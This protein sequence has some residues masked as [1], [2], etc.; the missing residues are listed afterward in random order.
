MEYGQFCPIAKASEILGEKWTILV[1]REIL[2]GASRF[3]DL[4]RGLGSISPTLLSR[5]LDSLEAAGLIVRKKMQ[6]QKGHAYF[7]T[8]PCKEL[9]PILEALGVWGLR[10][11]RANL[12]SGD[13]DVVLLMLYLERSIVPDALPSAETVIRFK[14]TDM[15][16]QADWWIVVKDGVLDT[17]DDDPGKDVDVFFTTTVKVMV[18]IWLGHKT[19]RKAIADDEISIVGT[20]ALVNNVTSWMGNSV[21]ADLPSAAHI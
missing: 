13:Y 11:A 6:G 14:F 5:R 8:A 7:P 16:K 21:Y 1:V 10:W 19:Y 9:S 3:S 17:C 12:T 18:D 2:A 4:Q 15:Q 20:R